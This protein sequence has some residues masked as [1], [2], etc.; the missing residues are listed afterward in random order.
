VARARGDLA[1]AERAYSQDLAISERLAELDPTNT[2]WQ[3]GLASAYSTVGDV[4]RARGDL[5]GAE[6]A[7]SQSLAIYKRLA[8]L[9][10]ANTNWQQ[11]LAVVRS[12]SVEASRRRARGR[13]IKFLKR[14]RR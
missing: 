10:P 14:L 3:E 12:L 8:E 9:D 2:G 4:A 5:A 1:G 11:G 6:R 7:Y 13:W